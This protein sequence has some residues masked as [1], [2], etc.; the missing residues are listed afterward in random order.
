MRMDMIALVKDIEMLKSLIKYSD[1][2]A[3]IARDIMQRNIISH[4][5]HKRRRIKI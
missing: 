1:T 5:T 2:L 4:F 3:P